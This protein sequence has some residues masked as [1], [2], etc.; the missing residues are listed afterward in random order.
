M[1]PTATRDFDSDIRAALGMTR[2]G[3]V[4]VAVALGSSRVAF[5]NH[6]S[7]FSVQR[8]PYG[9]S[10]EDKYLHEYIENTKDGGTKSTKN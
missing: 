1:T 6:Y 4:E 8:K 7:L 9:R 10:G 5:F 2:H 3:H